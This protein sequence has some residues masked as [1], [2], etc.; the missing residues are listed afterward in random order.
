M[1]I[2]DVRTCLEHAEAEGKKSLLHGHEDLA[3]IRQ[4]GMSPLRLGGAVDGIGK[5][6]ALRMGWKCSGG[7][8]LPMISVSP[9]VMWA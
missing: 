9:K 6:A 1:I 4:Q 3:A 8:S 7:T 5:V 2:Q